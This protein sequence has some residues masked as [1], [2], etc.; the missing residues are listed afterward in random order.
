MARNPWLILLLL[1]VVALLGLGCPSDDDDAA[2]DDDATGDDDTGDDDT[3]DDD[4]GD[5]DTSD[6]YDQDG[7]GSKTTD[8]PPD[9]DD[10]DP[11]IY[12]GAW[13]L[14]DYE[15][16][17]CDGDIDEQMPLH[18]Q[19]MFQGDSYDGLATELLAPGDATGD[20][21][22]DVLVATAIRGVLV[23]EGSETRCE[24]GEA[25]TDLPTIEDPGAGEAGFGSVMA[26]GDVDNDGD[27]EIFIAAPLEDGNATGAGVVYM[28]DL[29][30]GDLYDIDATFVGTTE[31]QNLGL[32][33]FAGEDISSDGIGDLVIGARNA[34]DTFKMFVFLGSLDGFDG[35][36]QPGDSDAAVEGPME[37]TDD[38]LV[39][40]HA[41]DLNGDGAV[42]LLVGTPS[43]GVND[44]GMAYM[45]FSSLVWTG[46]TLGNADVKFLPYGSS[47]ERLGADLGPAGDVVGGTTEDF[48]VAAPG[49]DGPGVG[50]GRIHIFGGDEHSWL[51][52]LTGEDAES[53][54]GA[55]LANDFGEATVAL[56]DI[57]LDGNDDIAVLTED[58]EVDDYGFGALYIVRGRNSG[59]P[60]T[61]E[62]S[63]RSSGYLAEAN[64]YLGPSLVNAGDMDGD[65]YD[66][67][68]VG[69]YLSG[70][71]D[72]RVYVIYT[73][74][75]PLAE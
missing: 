24:Y 30:D 61:H 14:W 12:P 39:L 48:F 2:D 41:P 49:W 19:C 1:P 25:S 72:G 56:G 16:N 6:P 60:E 51:G 52:A 75:S 59:L 47:D 17:D 9:C 7:D 63:E 21:L 20:G 46:R 29:S 62:L 66:D 71:G 45:L 43:A 27:V 50:R 54:V 38:E 33:I 42:E 13:E 40:G 32:A 35:E 28:H 26:A 74:E 67:I 69:D 55:S 36:L 18:R 68:V 58:H 11:T 70:W 44:D 5:D 31:G 73:P 53:T 57:E 64:D 10:T 34:P 65:G 8:D 22:A 4:T 37:T 3:G 23:I 15:D